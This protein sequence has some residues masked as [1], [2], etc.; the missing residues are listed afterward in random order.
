[1]ADRT[2]SPQSHTELHWPP[3]MEVEVNLSGGSSEK[4][5][6]R[7]KTRSS[8]A[9]FDVSLTLTWP[10][11]SSSILRDTW[12]RRGKLMMSLIVEVPSLTTAK[13]RSIILSSL[14]N[15][16][17][18]SWLLLFLYLQAHFGPMLLSS[19][20]GDL[21]GAPDLRGNIYK[22]CTCPTSTHLFL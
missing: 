6:G 16:K 20:L 1:M 7:V 22:S 12:Q 2:W 21:T 5:N 14:E 17:P 10:C 19:R 3:M 15:R 4:S 18:D 9:S 11:P 13:P 8:G